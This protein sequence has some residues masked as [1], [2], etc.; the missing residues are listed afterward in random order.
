MAVT[1]R[2]YVDQ[3]KNPHMYTKEFI[4]R[5]AG[6]NMYTNGILSAVT[7]RNYQAA[8]TAA[9][10]VLLTQTFALVI[11]CHCTSSTTGL[12]RFARCS[13]S[14]SISRVG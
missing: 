8:G 7:V 1:I 6:E 10:T 13:A 4:E 2:S 3:G 5:V 14:R 9:N 12:S 11:H